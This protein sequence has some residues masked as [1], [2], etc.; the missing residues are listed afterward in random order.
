MDQV[1]KALKTEEIEAIQAKQAKADL[2]AKQVLPAGFQSEKT[3]D[4]TIPVEFDG[5]VYGSISIRRLKG[6]DF[7]KLK[8]IAGDEDAGLLSLV[9][10][11]PPQV[12]GE[13]DADDYLRLADEARPF[14]PRSFLEG[15]APT[16]ASGQ[17][18]PR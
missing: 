13:L 1:V 4:L 15:A 8:K 10:D 12:L 9:T 14:L 6:A 18:S 16:S 17:A 2:K 3:I 11:C 5:V 7:G